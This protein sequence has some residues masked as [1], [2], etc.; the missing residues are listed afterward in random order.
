MKEERTRYIKG[1]VRGEQ[2]RNITRERDSQW[3]G[4]W[5]KEAEG[6]VREDRSEG[7]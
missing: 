2:G 4:K 1:D 3:R 6:L 5:E 7:R